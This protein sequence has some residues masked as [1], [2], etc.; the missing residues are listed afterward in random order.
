MAT[1]TDPVYAGVVEASE[2]VGTSPSSPYLM[3]THMDTF[4]I[5]HTAPITTACAR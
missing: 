1:T 3:A 4:S 2:A 5:A